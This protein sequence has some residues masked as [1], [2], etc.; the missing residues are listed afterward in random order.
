MKLR[1]SLPKVAFTILSAILLCGTANAASPQDDF[2]A[3]CQRGDLASA[4]RLIAKGAAI[5]GADREGRTPLLTAVFSKKVEVVEWLLRNGADANAEGRCPEANCIGHPALP[6]AAHF[7]ELRLVKMLLD[8]KADVAWKDNY[9]ARNANLHNEAELLKM[10]RAAGGRETGAPAETKP[11]PRGDA[12]IGVSELLPATAAA[13]AAPGEKLRV[14]IVADE[15]LSAPSDLLTTALTGKTFRLIE[16]SEL[17]RVLAEHKLTANLGADR[18]RAADLGAL[19]GADALVLLRKVKL[20]ETDSLEM[21]FVRVSPG[22]V[23]DSAYRAW[24]LNDANAWAADAAARLTALDPK[25]RDARAIAVATAPFRPLTDTAVSSQLARET[26]LLLNDR[27]ARQPGVVLLEREAVDALSREQGIGK[28]G[29]FWAGSYLL[30]GTVEPPASDAGQTAIT[31]RLATIGSGEV[32]TFTARGPRAELPR[33]IAELTTQAAAALQLRAA[34]PSDLK[35]EAQRHFDESRNLAAVGLPLA[36]Y[37]AAVIADAFGL[38]TD[39][40][41]EWHLD[42]ALQ[43]IAWQTQRLAAGSSFHELRWNGWS[44][45][46]IE[47]RMGG[48]EWLRPAEWCDLGV[49]AARLWRRALLAAL[50]AGGAPRAAALLTQNGSPLGGAFAVHHSLDLAATALDQHD[51]HLAIC[52]EV[53]AALEEARPLAEAQPALADALALQTARLAALLY[54]DPAT[55]TTAFTPLL[56]R[57]FSTDPDGS[58][59]AVRIA[60]LGLDGRTNSP[61]FMAPKSVAAGNRVLLNGDNL[62]PHGPAARTLLRKTLAPRV[63]AENELLAATIDYLDATGK[64]QQRVLS[65]KLFDLFWPRRQFFVENPDATRLFVSI[66]QHVSHAGFAP[67]FAWQSVNEPQSHIV[68]APEMMDLRRKLFLLI[69][70]DSAHPGT[71]F[72]L[73]DE[74]YHPPGEDARE[75]A[76]LRQRTVDD[77][78]GKLTSAPVATAPPK[79]R[80]VLR[81]TPTYAK[82]P[83]FKVTRRWIAEPTPHGRVENFWIRAP[84]YD[85]ETKVL[86][87]YGVSDSEDNAVHSFA[88][89]VSLPS[90]KTQ[91]WPLPDYQRPANDDSSGDVYFIPMRDRLYLVKEGEFLATGDRKTRE[92]KL[93]REVQP[94][95]EPARVGDALFFL[96]QSGDARGLFALSL[97]DQAITILASNRRTPPKTPLDRPALAAVDI[98]VGAN[99]LIEITTEP[100]DAT[101]RELTGEPKPQSR[102]TYDPAQ[103]IWTEPKPIEDADHGPPVFAPLT[104]AGMP[105]AYKKQPTSNVWTLQLPREEMPK[106]RIPIE[107]VAPDNTSPANP[108]S[109]AGAMT[110]AFST[111]WYWMPSG[112]IVIKSQRFGGSLVYFIP[113]P[114]LDAYLDAHVPGEDESS[115]VAPAPTKPS[116]KP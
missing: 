44:E 41:T 105:K 54:R 30:D 17:N 23:I 3:A 52:A 80:R 19:L 49:E 51:R 85:P 36:A 112:Y 72:T 22:I 56:A 78:D 38:D 39:E 47:K 83:P 13:K 61:T 89:E 79:P 66:C 33:L 110:D 62:T 101:K 84:A 111:R 15:T 60:L 28:A 48:A 94:V 73:F 102:V 103:Q 32:K 57:N 40:F 109:E 96:T 74:Y 35:A 75:I 98:K 7:G 1:R 68:H 16:R 42:T 14:A 53:R 6:I 58:R 76:R 67:K 12:V 63:S 99:G 2:V 29:G 100:F 26:S 65:E 71:A 20:G 87:L 43:L 114:E 34:P 5:N 31:L 55:L 106:V 92:W 108:S 50:R 45:A 10:L 77:W 64:D 93:N 90:L 86:W 69:A 18:T 25:I 46:W 4:Q 116:K 8:A 70:R 104:A 115:N 95:G 9:L 107:F 113:Q 24:P 27:L 91:T 11:K 88:F 81:S 37:R 97:H 82:F 59:L 21:R